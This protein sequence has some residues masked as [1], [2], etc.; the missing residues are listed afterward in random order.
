[1]D[2]PSTAASNLPDSTTD[3]STTSHPPE[4]SHE[5]RRSDRVRASPAHLHDYHCF[6]VLATHHEPHSYREA[7]DDP[8]WQKA[9]SDELY[10]FSKTHT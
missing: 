10:A 5:P 6:S 8:L 2:E 7:S 3:P 1:L 4:P 9:M